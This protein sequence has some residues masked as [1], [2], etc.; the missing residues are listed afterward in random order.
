MKLFIYVELFPCGK[1]FFIAS[2][3]SYLDRNLVLDKLWAWGDHSLSIKP[4][5]TSFNPL[6]KSLSMR[7][8]WARLPNLPL[9]FCEL[10]CYEAIE[11]YI[12]HFLKVD[13]ATSSMRHSTFA[14]FLVD[15]DISLPLPKDVVLMVGDRPW[16]QPL[17]NE[18]LPFYCQKCFSTRDLASGC[19]LPRH[20]GAATWWKDATI[21]HLIVNVLDSTCSSHEDD[22]SSRDEEPLTVVEPS[23]DP[24]IAVQQPSST[25]VEL[26]SS[27]AL[28]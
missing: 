27:A 28:L 13:E 15:I 1:G 25:T 8:I 6:T 22:V 10:S 19:S 12:G 17:D 2:F 4:W 18:G 20:R 3:A 24:L 9:H 5:T 11:N 26:A 7:P 21:E 14:R 16:S 23:T